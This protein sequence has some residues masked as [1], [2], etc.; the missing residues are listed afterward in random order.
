ME[1]TVQKVNLVTV[2]FTY[3]FSDDE[4]IQKWENLKSGLSKIRPIVNRAGFI[5]R[6]SKMERVVITEFIDSIIPDEG[7]QERQT[8]NGTTS[9]YSNMVSTN[10]DTGE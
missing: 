10:E 9:F 2:S 3:D 1:I 6:F 4:D 8:S 5:N 7:K